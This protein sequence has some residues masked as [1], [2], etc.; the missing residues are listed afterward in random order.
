MLDVPDVPD[1]FP[2][3]PEFKEDPPVWEPETLPDVF[4]SAPLFTPDEPLPAPDVPTPP[5]PVDAAK[6]GAAPSM[7]ADTAITNFT[8][9]MMFPPS[10]AATAMDRRPED[11]DSGVPGFQGRTVRKHLVSAKN[12]CRR[13]S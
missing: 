10:F 2:L 1:E 6:A 4:V 5:A 9:F 12:S 7:S 8:V 13:S 3:D 11:Y